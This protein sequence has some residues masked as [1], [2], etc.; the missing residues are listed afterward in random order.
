MKTATNGINS[1]QEI[2]SNKMKSQ[3]FGVQDEQGIG[4]KVLSVA[5]LILDILVLFFRLTLSQIEFIYKQ[6]VPVEPKSVKD[7]II[8]ITGS[9][10]GIGRELSLQYAALGGIIVCV[11]INEAGN[12]ETVKEVKANGGKAHAYV[13]DVSKSDKVKEL[14]DRIRKEVGE[15]SVLVNNAGIMPC[16]QF[17]DHEEAEI[18]KMFDVNVFAHFWLNKAFLPSMIMKNRG[19]IVALSSM[20]GV[21][22]LPNLVPYCGSKFAVRGIMEALG[23]ELRADPRKLHI[24]TTTIY[25]YIVDTGLCQR[26]KIRFPSILGIVKPKEAAAEIIN[27]MR[28]E[29]MEHSIPFTMLGL[30]NW[31]RI[32]PNKFNHVLKDFIDSGLEAHV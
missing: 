6:F 1:S 25:P 17:L 15:V 19:H 8:L 4:P 12:L 10:H 32:Q 3:T 28:I 29:K 5:M 27:A 16:K 9:G 21:I 11:D 30:N 23:E 22:G 13:C 31:C 14:A 26:P 18:R 20:A 7:E 24:K 2:S